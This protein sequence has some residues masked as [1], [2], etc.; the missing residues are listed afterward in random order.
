MP[1][2]VGHQQGRYNPPSQHGRVDWYPVE[3]GFISLPTFELLNSFR[4][5]RNNNLAFFYP[6]LFLLIETHVFY[7]LLW[8]AIFRD[9]LQFPKLNG[10]RKILCET[11]I[12]KKK[13]NTKFIYYYYLFILIFHKNN[14]S[15]LIFLW[16]MSNS[17]LKVGRKKLPVSITP[18]GVYVVNIQ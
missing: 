12:W 10:L 7:L 5:V 1:A 14:N 15:M 4:L 13:E 16:I 8:A 3:R 2:S 6:S 9:V 11:Q 17:F 18:P